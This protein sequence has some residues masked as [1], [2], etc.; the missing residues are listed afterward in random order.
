MQEKFSEIFALDKHAVLIDLQALQVKD[1]DLDAYNSNFN[2]IASKYSW[3]KAD[4]DNLKEAYT[5]SLPYKC[6]EKM[7]I[8]RDYH[9]MTLT[10]LQAEA[11]R[12][13]K[14]MTIMHHANRNNNQ[15]NQG[16]S[17]AIEEPGGKGGKGG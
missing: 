11:L 6:K 17:K 5:R 14:A 9:R 2:R 7:L 1:W 3:N 4:D 10:Q 16:K 12:T 15:G 13:Q 8:D